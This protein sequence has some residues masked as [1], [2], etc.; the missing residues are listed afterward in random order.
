VRDVRV[1]KL[2]SGQYAVFGLD[3]SP[4]VG[5]A[6]ERLGVQRARALGATHYVLSGAHATVVGAVRLD[7]P[8]AKLKGSLHSAAAIFS[9]KH[10]V[11]AIAYVLPDPAGSCWMIACHA[12]SVL[13]HTDRWYESQAAALVALDPLRSRFPGLQV[14]IEQVLDQHGLPGWLGGKLCDQSRLRSVKTFSSLASTPLKICIGLCLAASLTYGFLPTHNTAL[15]QE[16]QDTQAVWRATLLEVSGQ[17]T[18]HAFSHLNALIQTWQHI[19]LLPAGW[20][21]RKIQCESI[22]FDWQCT[23]HFSRQYRWALNQHLEDVKPLGWSMQFT[24]LDEAAFVWRV[25]QA[26]TT[27]DLSE[28]WMAYDWMSYLQSIGSAFEHI[29]VSAAT[30]LSIQAPRDRQGDALALPASVPRWKQRTLVVKGPLRSLVAL[31]RFHMPVRWR[32]AHLDIDRAQGLGTYRSALSLELVGDMFE[33]R[34]E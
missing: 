21:L 18:V 3:W 4:L 20:I 5:G 26:A 15:Q 6:P 24:P 25:P 8:V 28:H 7:P 27:L 10:A 34:S 22:R 23:A 1:R 16:G 30:R 13:A 2:I 32:R 17:H 33:S 12:G 29:Q 9:G 19:P 31:D 14:Q 11:G